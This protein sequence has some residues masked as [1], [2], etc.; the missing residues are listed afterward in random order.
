MRHSCPL[1]EEFI[2]QL[3]YQLGKIEMLLHQGDLEVD[4]NRE[5]FAEVAKML[6][7]LEREY[8][9]KERDETNK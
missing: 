4:I 9:K 7:K 5:G 2:K 3:T 1:L 6:H 8:D